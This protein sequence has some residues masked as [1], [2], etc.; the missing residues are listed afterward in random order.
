MKKLSR[1]ITLLQDVITHPKRVLN[2]SEWK[3]L[4]ELNKHLSKVNYSAKEAW[5]DDPEDSTFKK[6]AYS[7]YEEYLEHQKSKIDKKP[8]DYLKEYE[9][10]FHKTLIQRLEAIDNIASFKGKNA[11]CLGA[12]KGTEVRSFL[13][14]GCFAVGIDLNPTIGN[15]YVVC[16]DFHNIQFSDFSVDIVYTNSFDHVF[17]PEKILS[18]INRI[19]KKDGVFILEA[20]AMSDP[21]DLS[22]SAGYYYESFCWSE[23]Q[24]LIEIIERKGFTVKSR[25]P[26]KYP[27]HGEQILFCKVTL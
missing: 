20:V 3:K 8:L 19:L 27:W 6:K 22:V 17:S 9:I 14:L 11:L 18:E 10:E 13:D 12:R 24:H 4:R 26:F 23:I 1:A 15:K 21:E 16:G 25:I 5:V 2:I 7:S